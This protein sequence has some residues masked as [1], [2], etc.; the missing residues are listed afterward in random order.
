SPGAFGHRAVIGDGAYSM[1][2]RKWRRTLCACGRIAGAPTCMIHS[3]RNP[4]A[5]YVYD[6]FISYLRRDRTHKE[7]LEKTFKPLFEDR[8]RQDIAEL[9]GRA[10]EKELFIDEEGIDTGERITDK[11]RYGLKHSRCLV[12]LWSPLY[13]HSRWCTAEWRSFANRG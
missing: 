10:P 9:C 2:T 5:D 6:I 4:M 11:L 7:W 1:T 12:G 3:D 8:V 13:F